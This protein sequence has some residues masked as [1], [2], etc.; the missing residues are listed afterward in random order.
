MP[1]PKIASLPLSKIR[2]DGG[3]QMRVRIDPEVVSE[4]IQFI[5]SLPPVIV[6][7]D[8][9]DYW[10]VDGFTRYQ[11]HELSEPPR[12]HILCEVRPGSKRDAVLAATSANSAHGLR[13]SNADKRRAV[14]TLLEDAEWGH[15]SNREIARRCAVDE[16]TVRNYR[17]PIKVTGISQDLMD[18]IADLPP[19]DQEEI[20][21]EAEK[22]AASAKVKVTCPRCRGKG[23]IDPRTGR[24]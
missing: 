12:N 4:Y 11:A 13:R 22:E 21:Q 1:T 10:L 18:Q 20:I 19:E 3:T 16:A 9:S 5:D 14:M 2:L 15:W 24:R 8:G 7:F 6:F 23:S 17:N